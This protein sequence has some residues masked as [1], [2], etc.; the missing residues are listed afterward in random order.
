M[1]AFRYT[2][3]YTANIKIYNLHYYTLLYIFILA[4]YIKRW[5]IY[6]RIYVKDSKL[7]K[8]K[9]KKISKINYIQ[10]DAFKVLQ[11]L[12]LKVLN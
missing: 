6:E 5:P 10:S 9:N 11:V 7:M 3:I 8:Y 4:A 1:S 12:S 2:G